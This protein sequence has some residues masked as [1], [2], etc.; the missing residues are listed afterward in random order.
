MSSLLSEERM[1]IFVVDG[2]ICLHPELA[3]LFLLLFFFSLV[4]KQLVYRNMWQDISYTIT[5]EEKLLGGDIFYGWK[6]RESF[7]FCLHED[8][9]FP[10]PGVIG[11]GLS[12]EGL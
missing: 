1:G 3:L 2:D 4:V 6:P 10:V 11:M 9:C 5:K 8:P 12:L 7:V